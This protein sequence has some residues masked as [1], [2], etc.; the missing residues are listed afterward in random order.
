MF[1][2]S[3]IVLQSRVTKE[4]LHHSKSENVHAPEFIEQED[5]RALKTGQCEL[6]SLWVRKAVSPPFRLA[7]TLQEASSHSSHHSPYRTAPSQGTDPNLSPDNTPQYFS[8]NLERT[9][10][11]LLQLPHFLPLPQCVQNPARPLAIP[12]ATNAQ[13]ERNRLTMR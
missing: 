3:N 7:R 13:W 8:S 9:I 10:R 6:N 12:S 2:L 5:S 11:D 1:L 4:I